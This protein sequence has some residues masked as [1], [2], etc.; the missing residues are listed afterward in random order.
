MPFAGPLSLSLL[1]VSFSTP[2]P[3]AAF[4]FPF[5]FCYSC[6]CC[7]S[8]LDAAINSTAWSKDP[9]MIE[10]LRTIYIPSS[11]SSFPFATAVDAYISSKHALLQPQRVSRFLKL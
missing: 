8:I 3:C 4:P 7:C 11:S 10:E 9:D 5:P 2:S 6:C 1:L